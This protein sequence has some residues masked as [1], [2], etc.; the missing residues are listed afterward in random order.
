MKR[1]VRQNSLRSTVKARRSSVLSS[2]E[3]RVASVTETVSRVME[4]WRNSHPAQ[5]AEEVLSETLYFERQ[6]LKKDV[7]APGKSEDLQFW[8]QAGRNLQSGSNTQQARLLEDVVQRYAEEIIGHFNPLLF[9]GLTKYGAPSL[10]VLLNSMSPLKLLSSLGDLGRIDDNVA[11]VGE[12]E[13][14]LQLSTR[15]S[16]VL[17]PTHVSN[18]DSVVLGFALARLGLPPFLYGAGYNLFKHPLLAPFMRRLGA[19]TV[20]REKKAPLYKQVLKTYATV[21]MEMGRHHIFFPGGTRSRSGKVERKLKKGLLGCGLAAYAHQIKRGNYKNKVFIVPCTLTYQMVLEA[22]TLVADHLAESGKARYIILDDESSRVDKVVQFV[23]ALLK[24]QSRISMHIGHALDPFGN[25]VLANGESVDRQG[26]PIDISGYLKRDGRVVEDA[27]RD[28]E[29]TTELAEQICASY[30]RGVVVSP[31]HL[32][33]Y[34]LFDMLRSEQPV[35]LIRLLRDGEPHPGFA[36]E[37]LRQR[38]S[39]RLVTLRQMA[40]EGKLSLESVLMSGSPDEILSRALVHFSVYHA[41]AVVE[42]RGTRV[43][44]LDRPLIYYYRNRLDG[45]DL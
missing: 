19:Y 32:V 22:E 33:A 39:D 38:L 42:R 26:R 28:E 44:V 20:D 36:I 29:F 17:V 16:I 25:R 31:T 34:E 1:L 4:W 18:F 40:K 15:G 12:V 2:D 24:N 45:F 21:T 41:T 13:S 5:S 11:V 30:P 27:Q 37:P 10:S 3:D 9:E 8:R 43:F 35:D 23:R 14:L 7:H 6:R